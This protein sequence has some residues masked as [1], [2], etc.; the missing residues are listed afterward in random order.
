MV[1]NENS[2]QIEIMDEFGSTFLYTNDLAHDLLHVV[3]D[4]LSKKERW[5]DADYLSRM[6]FC[7]MVPPEQW[8]KS[9]GFGIGTQ[10]YADVKFLIHINIVKQKLSVNNWNETGSSCR[11]IHY[12][13]Q[14]FIDN[15]TNNASL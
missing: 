6:L 15:F 12:T 13:F 2:G 4:V 10:M 14:D 1:R 5:N 7:R 9:D 11:A 8:S 3:H